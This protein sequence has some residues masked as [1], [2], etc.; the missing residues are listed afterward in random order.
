MMYVAKSIRARFKELTGKDYHE[1]N[2][3]LL[4]RPHLDR[5]AAYEFMREQGM[6]S[7]IDFLLWSCSGWIQYTSKTHRPLPGDQAHYEF[8]KWVSKKEENERYLHNH[9]TLDDVHQVEVYYEDGNLVIDCW[10][11]TSRYEDEKALIVPGEALP[12]LATILHTDASGLTSAIRSRFSGGSAFSDM[13]N[14][15]REHSI[16]YQL[17]RR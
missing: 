14:L 3:I 9:M 1:W 8:L 6:K 13:E 17:R 15:L 2:D 4:S 10:V 7:H 5:L 11:L 12:L 16:P